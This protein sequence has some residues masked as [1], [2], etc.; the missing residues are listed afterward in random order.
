MTVLERYQRIE[1]DGVWQPS[2]EAQ[3]RNVFVSLGEATL[4][5]KDTADTALAHWSLPAVERIDAGGTPARYRPGDA[6]GEELEISDE[7]MIEA[8]RTVQAALARAR[9]HPGRLRRAVLLASLAA[10]VALAVVWLPGA[11]ARHTAAVLPAPLTAEI[12]QRMLRDLR[13]IT[14]APC[15]APAGL[16][17]LADLRGKVL[18]G[19]G[20]NVVVV[21]GGPVTSAALPGRLIV[22]RADLLTD[23]NGP[24]AA[25]GAIVAEATR[26]RAAP[27]LDAFLG[28]AGPWASLS[29]LTRGEVPEAAIAAHAETVLIAPR[30]DV[31]AARFHAAFAE[32][33]LPAAP[34]LDHAAPPE[35]WKA[36]RGEPAAAPP[37]G[38]ADWQTLRAICEG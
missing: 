26:L 2:A 30:P 28:D 3:R 17:V 6:A 7:T 12:G 11:L 35:S 19:R 33:G 36:P 34:Y 23:A 32:A 20:W 1:C 22:L 18:D 38:D 25:A 5:I 21:P 27:P 37:I 4:I 24:E 29:L 10:A 31:P 16:A 8:I 15:T 13:P 9:P 14:G